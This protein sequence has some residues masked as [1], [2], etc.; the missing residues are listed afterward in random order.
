MQETCGKNK[1]R[2][3]FRKTKETN[4][5]KI[6]G[7]KPPNHFVLNP[8]NPQPKFPLYKLERMPSNSR[9]RFSLLP[10]IGRCSL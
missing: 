5:I 4:F 2:T 10:F 1:Q 6:N 9:F 3:R 8:Q 7:G